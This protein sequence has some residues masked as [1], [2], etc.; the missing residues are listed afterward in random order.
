M[1]PSCKDP[2]VVAVTGISKSFGNGRVVA[3]VSL[4]ATSGM[5]IGL[6]GPNGAGKST[7]LKIIYGFLRPSWLLCFDAN[8]ISF[9]GRPQLTS[10]SS[11]PSWNI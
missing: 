1:L 5:C 6:L 3:N 11:I 2:P 9:A 4:Y 7:T 8:I 10:F